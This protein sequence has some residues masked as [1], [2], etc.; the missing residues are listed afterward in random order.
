MRT[1]SGSLSNV[2]VLT[3]FVD[4][5]DLQSILYCARSSEYS[6]GRFASHSATDKVGEIE[7]VIDL[8]ERRA[9]YEF[10]VSLSR[11]DGN[12]LLNK[13]EVGDNLTQ[14]IDSAQDFEQFLGSGAAWPPSVVLYSSILYLNDDYEGG[15]IR[16]TEHGVSVKPKAGTLLIFPSTDM[17]PH[18]VTEITSGTRYTF[19]LFLSNKDMIDMFKRLYNIADIAYGKRENDEI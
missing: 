6:R 4:E 7:R 18:E 1:Q 10:G 11:Y 12:G 2:H 16:F 13:W 5:K 3:N 8:I 9:S 19:A 15:E 17:Y 14:H